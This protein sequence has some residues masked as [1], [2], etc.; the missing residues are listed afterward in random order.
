MALYTPG[1]EGPEVQRTMFRPLVVL[2]GILALTALGY[3]GW[4]LFSGQRPESPE[5]LARAA[6]EAGTAEQR[7]AAAVKLCQFGKP[8][9][10]H[11]LHV[12]AE[13]QQP[14]VRAACI[15]GLAEQWA[16]RHM[17]VLLDLLDDGDP[18]V[19]AQAGDGVQLMLKVEYGFNANAPPDQ[20][21]EVVR[22]LRQR[23]KE[24]P[25][26]KVRMAFI[27]EVEGDDFP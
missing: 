2:S 14:E 27:R 15:R 11:L 5:A 12:L 18:L 6:L 23:W 16:Y 3:F 7:E 8:T 13:S 25:E 9:R 4:L 22:R 17:R 20:R 24:F 10:E 19:R 21:R 1:V 26:S